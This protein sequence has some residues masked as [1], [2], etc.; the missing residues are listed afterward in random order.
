[1]DRVFN[2]KLYSIYSLLIYYVSHIA[3]PITKG[4]PGG[5][6]I[7]R[8]TFFSKS[9]Y[10]SQK[11]HSYVLLKTY[12][13][14]VCLESSF[15]SRMFWYHPEKHSNLTIC[16]C[17]Q[18]THFTKFSRNRS[19]NFAIIFPKIGDIARFWICLLNLL[20]KLSDFVFHATTD[21]QIARYFFPMDRRI[22]RIFLGQSIS[23]FLPFF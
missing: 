20:A 22:L 11:G 6:F 9:E 3:D 1:M 21:W 18:L 7:K 17:N 23:E 13:G 5:N 12:F 14:L 19:T 2:N 16:Y 15:I 10:C 4:P 8:C